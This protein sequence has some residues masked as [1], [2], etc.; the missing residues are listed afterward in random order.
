MEIDAAKAQADLQ[1][2]VMKL[3][4]ELQLEREKNQA[5]I[6]I[7]AMKDGWNFSIY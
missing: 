1:A 6:Q 2:K 5:K 7:E 4:T 3:E